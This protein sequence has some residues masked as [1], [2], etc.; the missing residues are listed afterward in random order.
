VIGYLDC[1]SGI[2]GDM[3]LG[4]IV[5]AGIP[6]DR[7]SGAVAGLSIAG[8]ERLE[9]STVS[10]GGLRATKVDVVVSGEQPHHRPFRE[11]ER[12]LAEAALEDVVR[13]RSLAVLRRLAEVEGRIHGTPPDQVELHEVGAIDSIVD[14]VGSV[15]GLRMLGIDRLLASPLP[16]SPGSISG[17]VHPALPAPAPATL[18]LL[19]AVHAPLRSFGDGRELVTP[20]GAAL[21][22]TLAAFDPPTMRVERVGYGAGVA[23]LPWPNV[24]RLWL[25]TPLAEVAPPPERHVILETAV[26]DMSPQL[27]APV[28][29]SLFAAGALDVTFSPLQ[30]KKGRPATLVTVVADEAAEAPLAELLL[31][32]TTTLGVRVHGVRRYEAGRTLRSIDTPYG[33]VEVKLKILDGRVAGAMPEFESVRAVAEAAS[34]PLSRVHAAAMAAAQ[35]LLDDVL[36]PTD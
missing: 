18:D 24:L 31:R 16:V 30:M 3:T 28:S 1:Y 22:A 27:L 12:L 7:L 11:I 10:R 15:I 20:T 36:P 35:G 26:D 8:F 2:S 29:D 6:V 34:V 32:E 33:P 25:G 17:V 21:V 5:D 23:E 19:A 4:A 9:A 14:V 13:D